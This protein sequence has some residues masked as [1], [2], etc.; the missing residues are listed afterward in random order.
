M[1]GCVI[2]LH[3]A[4][5]NLVVSISAAIFNFSFIII[6]QIDMKGPKF[7]YISC[8]DGPFIQLY[9]YLKVYSQHNKYLTV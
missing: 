7:A 5:C 1:T 8:L 3:D 9:R 2:L 6:T 4:P